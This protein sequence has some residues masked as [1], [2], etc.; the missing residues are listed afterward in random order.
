MENQDKKVL[1]LAM[2]A[3][4]ILLDAG[5]EI[6][7]VEETMKRIAKAY[8]IE[9]FNSF[10]LS[11]GIFITAENQEGEIYAS[12]KHIPIQS[13]K[14][15]RIAAVNQLSREIAE[16][17][18]TPQEAIWQLERI[19]TMPE[20][21]TLTKMLAAGVGSGGFCYILGGH[22]TDMLA[23]FLSGFLLYVI[24]TLLQ[25]REKETSKI[26]VNLIGGFSV[27]LFSVLFYNMGL[28]HAP[29]TILVGSIMPLVPGVS[30]V[31]AI[32]DFAEG[33][34][35]GGGVRFLDALMVAL[36]VSL[37]VG[38]MYILYFRFTGRIIL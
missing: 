22:L 34:Y 27:S 28:G 33:N 35:I 25:K 4:R 17:K 36:G 10:V 30:L 13:A 24:L 1:D 9:K 29:G 11:T 5:A 26:V 18:Y 12:V 6:F 32:R 19:K 15:H 14:L 20:K 31:N 16:G 7:R 2:E 38:M 23:A 8:G 21:K 37:G 3:G